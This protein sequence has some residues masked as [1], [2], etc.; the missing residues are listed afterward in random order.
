MDPLHSPSDRI[1]LDIFQNREREAHGRRYSP[2][3]LRWAW[4]IY[5]VSP[6]AWE[7][8]RQALPL[9]CERVLQGHFSA[10]GAVISAAL[11]DVDRV[12][13]LIRLWEQ[14]SPETAMDRRIVL[15]VDAVAFRP[16]VTIGSDGE[17][18]GLDD[19]KNL[20]S[21]DL[22]DQYLLHP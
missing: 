2:E 13:E 14:S 10:S 18:D 1:F 16:R 6:K 9:P 21:P 20:E 11:V 17:V 19:I 7:I 15:A 12:G 3:T 4:A 22:F 5:G 8:I